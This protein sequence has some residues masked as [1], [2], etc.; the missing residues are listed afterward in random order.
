M[1]CRLCNWFK[2]RLEIS[3]MQYQMSKLS[4]RELHDMGI[5]RYDVHRILKGET[6]G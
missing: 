5:T 6:I 3:R 1:L 2:D 4:D